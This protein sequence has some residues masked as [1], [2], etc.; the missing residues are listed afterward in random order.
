MAKK[1]KKSKKKQ[2]DNLVPVFTPALVSTLLKREKSKGAPLTE[3]E[4]LEIRDNSTLILVDSS[5]AQS[6]AETR[7]YQD[8]DPEHTWEQWVK[9]RKKLLKK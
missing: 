9:I 7:G 4:V 8:L 2:T 5:E 3:E 6:M 1:S